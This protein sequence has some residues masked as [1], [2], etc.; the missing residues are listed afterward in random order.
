[1]LEP[2]VGGNEDGVDLAD[3]IL[4]TCNDVGDQRDL[5]DVHRIGRIVGPDMG[6]LGAG[7][8]EGPGRLLDDVIADAGI[9]AFVQRIE[10]VAAVEDDAPRVWVAVA[11]D[12]AEHGETNFILLEG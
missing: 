12:H 6:D 7:D 10:V 2:L 8:A 1:M 5:G 11:F 3:D 4:G 9:R